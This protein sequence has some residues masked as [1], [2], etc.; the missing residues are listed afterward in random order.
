MLCFYEIDGKVD[1]K[2]FY[3]C[4]RVNQIILLD[5]LTEATKEKFLFY[6][7]SSINKDV[8]LVSS[9]YDI[10]NHSVSMKSVNELLFG[11]QKLFTIDKVEMFFK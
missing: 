2:I 1:D 4:S 6:F 5:S 9:Y 10:I 11:E 3:K 8:Y 7:N